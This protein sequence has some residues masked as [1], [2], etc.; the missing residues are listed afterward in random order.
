VKKRPDDAFPFDVLVP[1]SGVYAEDIADGKRA[2]LELLI[3]GVDEEGRT[4]E[5]MVIPFSVTLD[6]SAADGTFFRK[7]SNFTLD[8]KWKGRLFV[9]VRDT[10][11]NRI[12][13]VALPVGM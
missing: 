12:G 10:S 1:V 4:S 5:P 11:T 8:R 7:N 2:K 13:A 9:G 3:A 6:K